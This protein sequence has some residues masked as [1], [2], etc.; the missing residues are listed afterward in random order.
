MLFLDAATDSRS[1]TWPSL[2]KNI[3]GT[4]LIL[5]SEARVGDLSMSI[6]AIVTFKVLSSAISSRSGDI[7]L[8]GP[9]QEAEKTASFP[10]L[11]K[12]FF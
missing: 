7:I 4:D 8:H 11:E 2:K 5:I 6:F 9:H 1:V 10:P 12:R 3:D